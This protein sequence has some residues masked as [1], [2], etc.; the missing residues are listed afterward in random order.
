MCIRG[1]HIT[2]Q[3]GRLTLLYPSE[4][5]QR[6]VAHLGTSRCSAKR[7]AG[8]P[9]CVRHAGAVSHTAQ[10]GRGDEGLGRGLG[11]GKRDTCLGWALGGGEDG[12]WRRRAAGQTTRAKQAVSA[13][14][15][16]LVSMLFIPRRSLFPPVC[17]CP[18]CPLFPHQRQTSPLRRRTGTSFQLHP[19]HTTRRL[20]FDCNI[21]PLDI[22]KFTCWCRK[23]ERLLDRNVWRTV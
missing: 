7:A 12:R 10:C 18:R 21:N 9:R 20:I 14:F 8:W 22:Q 2:S 17:L 23:N 5:R 11:Q 19:G 4:H 15:E 13:E 3:C 6:R 16:S 1:S